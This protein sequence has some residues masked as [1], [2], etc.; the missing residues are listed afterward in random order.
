MSTGIHRGTLGMNM[1]TTIYTSYKTVVQENIA[2]GVG[3]EG[4]HRV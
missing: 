3:R 2:K 1:K 4:E